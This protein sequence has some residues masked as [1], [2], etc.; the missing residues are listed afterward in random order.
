MK[1][2]LILV[3]T[4]I[5][6]GVLGIGVHNKRKS[7]IEIRTNILEEEA[8][9][10]HLIG[11]KSQLERDLGSTPLDKMKVESDINSCNFQIENIRKNISEKEVNL[12]KVQNQFLVY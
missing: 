12:K 1:I 8:Q 2:T 10:R 7:I 6:F 11:I 3:I 5:L 4:F 9:V